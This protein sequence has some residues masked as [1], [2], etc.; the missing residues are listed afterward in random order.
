MESK[1]AYVV[2]VPTGLDSDGNPD[3]SPLRSAVGTVIED[4]QG[5]DLIILESTVDIGCTRR[6]IAD[7][8]GTSKGHVCVGFSPERINPGGAPNQMFSTPKLVSGIDPCCL[9]KVAG[10][11]QTM[12]QQVVRA[13]C[14]EVAETA[15]L[16]ENSFR[17]LNLAWMLELGNVFRGSQISLV[18]AV[19]LA[20]TKPFG[21]IPF[22]PGIG[23]GGHCIPIDPVYLQ[24]SLASLT[25]NGESKFIEL[26]LK[27][28]AENYKL[29]HTRIIASAKN[30][31]IVLVG[32]TYKW[33]ISDMR[34]SKAL[35]LA[36]TL[37]AN[38]TKFRIYDP[39]VEVDTTDFEFVSDLAELSG[40]A[41]VIFC[42]TTKEAADK[43]REIGIADGQVFRVG[44]D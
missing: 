35:D 5:F 4:A 13:S 14:T 36:R 37:K 1:R 2:C 31:L 25:P 38:G 3:Y 10:F 24:N 42:P 15:K 7:R 34:N 28:N 9:E 18:E 32:L 17:L 6:E 29:D 16:L 39:S 21:Y 12:V 40:R 20:A 30:K 41:D 19:E 27:Q 33:G 23:A 44:L 11:Y 22:Y 43:I 8:V 26:A